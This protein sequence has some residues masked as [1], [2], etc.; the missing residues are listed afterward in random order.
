MQ[1]FTQFKNNLNEVQPSS[2]YL[3]EGEDGYFRERGLNLL[4]EKYVSEP[5]LNYT[6]LGA[7]CEFDQLLASLNGYPFMSQKRMTVVRE[8]YPKQE[9]FKKGLKSFFE[10]PSP[11]GIFVIL[12]EKPFE[13]FKKFET[14]CVVDCAKADD[15][16]LLRWVRAECSRHNVAIDGECAK[17]LCE[18]CLSDMTRIETETK[19]LIAYALD[20]GTITMDDINLMVPRTT[21]YKIYEMTDYIAKRKFDQSLSV[22]NDLLSKGET[23]HS[24]LASVYNYFRR[25]LHAAISGKTAT[26]LSQ[27]L[28]IKEYPA[29]KLLEQAR[30]FKKRA[31]K[32]AVDRLVEADYKI[33]SGRSEATNEMWITIFTIMTE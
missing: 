10:N 4:K 20:S 21:E 29:K 25:L 31:L 24:I 5:D 8:F 12:N 7:D 22:I 32:S 2:I 19:K 26:E 14:V 1:K 13:A 28:K 9:I 11:D 18:Y 16:L 6:V 33:K 15:T 17:M 30:L 3:F 27:S 23:P